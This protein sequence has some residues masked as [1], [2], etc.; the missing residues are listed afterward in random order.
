MVVGYTLLRKKV[1]EE[2][3]SRRHKCHWIALLQ[4][5][6]TPWQNY[7]LGYL[8]DHSKVEDSGEYMIELMVKVKLV[9]REASLLIHSTKREWFRRLFNQLKEGAVRK[10]HGNSV[11]EP[12]KRSTDCIAW[13]EFLIIING[14][15]TQAWLHLFWCSCKNDGAKSIYQL[16][17][18]FYLQLDIRVKENKN[19]CILWLLALLIELNI[20]EKLKL[21]Y[22]WQFLS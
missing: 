18:V 11:K 22:Q 3:L 10:E 16:P 15:M 21:V 17:S 8:S 5:E 13:L 2:T 20:F 14:L 1:Y 9:C 12:S 6:L 19:H 4:H 7:F